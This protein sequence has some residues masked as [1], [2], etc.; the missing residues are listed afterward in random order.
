MCGGEEGV[1]RKSTAREGG[2]CVHGQKKRQVWG[3]I[4][5]VSLSLRE[6]FDVKEGRASL[7]LVGTVRVDGF[8]WS[9]LFFVVETLFRLLYLYLQFINAREKCVLPSWWIC[10]GYVLDMSWICPPLGRLVCTERAF[11]LRPVLAW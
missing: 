9:G 10:P 3:N 5:L 1:R 6:R 11:G 7:T 2:A 4:D 8:L